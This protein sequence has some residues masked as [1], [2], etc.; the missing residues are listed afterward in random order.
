MAPQTEFNAD[1]L[2]K[3]YSY[4]ISMLSFGARLHYIAYLSGASP[5]ASARRPTI[6][7]LLP[8]G[9]QSRVAHPVRIDRMFYGWVK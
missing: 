9:D 5:S 2:D 3:T 7:P 6:D 1:P 8:V 4:V